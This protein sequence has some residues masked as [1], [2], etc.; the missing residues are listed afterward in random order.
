MFS[1]PMHELTNTHHEARAV[2]GIPID[3]LA[4]RLNDGR[5][6]EDRVRIADDFFIRRCSNLPSPDRITSAAL[7]ILGRRGRIQ[8]PAL[9]QHACMSARQ[10]ERRFTCEIGLS[11]KLFARIA[12][13]ESALESKALSAAESWTDITSRLGYFDQ[14]HL[15]KDFK[16]FSGEIPTSLLAQLETAY[17]AHLNEIRSGRKPANPR[18]SPQLIL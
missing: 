17:N 13:F 10:F 14:M 12:R 11:P 3:E 6:F 15:I 5:S 7:S 4:D 1:V 9:A 2:L 8:V 16:E 18:G